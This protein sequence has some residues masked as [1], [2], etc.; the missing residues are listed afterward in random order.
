MRRALGRRQSYITLLT[1]LEQSRVIEVVDDRT[2]EA[3][4]LWQA[5]TPKQKE[6]VEAVAVDM[7]ERV[8][9]DD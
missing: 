3:A 4:Q 6:A 2:A 5:L 1:V 9:S 7:R 8:H